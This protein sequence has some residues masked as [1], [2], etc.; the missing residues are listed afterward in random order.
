MVLKFNGSSCNRVIQIIL[1]ILHSSLPQGF[2]FTFQSSLDVGVGSATHVSGG[3]F[4]VVDAPVR[5]AQF[6]Q[7]EIALEFESAVSFSLSLSCSFCREFLFL[8][9]SLLILVF[10][11]VKPVIIK[12]F[13]IKV[14]IACKFITIIENHDPSWL[15]VHFTD[16]S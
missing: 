1:R 9:W 11:V 8:I 4:G 15:L 10:E 7:P 13:S 5:L 16:A 3:Y 12:D 2:P 6:Q 14:L